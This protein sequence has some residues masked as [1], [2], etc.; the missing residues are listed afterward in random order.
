MISSCRHVLAIDPGQRKSGWVLWDVD[1]GSVLAAE[2]TDNVQCREIVFPWFMQRYDTHALLPIIETMRSYGKD[3]GISVFETCFWIGRFWD[4]FS[5]AGFHTLTLMRQDHVG[6]VLLGRNRRFNNGDIRKKLIEMYG[7]PGTKKTPGATAL[8]AGNGGHTW[9]AAALAATYLELL[10]S[11]QAYWPG[12]TNDKTK[13][14]APT[15]MIAPMI[16]D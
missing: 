9:Q 6:Q 4:M 1:V 8:L 14:G 15:K 16:F 13:K 11:G 7:A 2:H 12:D 5:C 10:K 3:V